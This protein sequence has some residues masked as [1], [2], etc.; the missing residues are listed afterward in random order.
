MSDMIAFN[1]RVNVKDGRLD[2]FRSLMLDLVASIRENEPETLGYEWFLGEDGSTCH[3]NERYAN[4][5]V[6]VAHLASFGSKFAERFLAAADVTG[7]TVYG[8]PNA[9]ARKLLD[10]FGAVYL[11]TFG[12]FTR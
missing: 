7:L 3:I 6:L 8:E 1:L 12:G 2:E 11:G 5:A 4:S 9:D 10:G